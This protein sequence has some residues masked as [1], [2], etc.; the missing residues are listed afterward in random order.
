M[1]L[2]RKISGFIDRMGHD[3]KLFSVKPALIVGGITLLLGMLSW[4][5]GGRIDKVML[6]YIFPRSAF[7]LGLMYFMWA[8]FFLFLGIIIGGV[9]F[10]CEKY[11]RKESVK[12]V[13]FLVVSLLFTLLIYPVFFKS[14]APFITFIIIFISAFFCLMALMTCS[15][16]YSLWTICIAIYM[17]WLIYNG[18][19][20]LCIALIN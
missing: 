10:G 12:A 15:R 20:S 19:L 17:L 3:I 13:I 18:Y 4:V 5:V 16:I 9:A 14:M 6:I 11:K 7:S 8:L 1:K 2:F